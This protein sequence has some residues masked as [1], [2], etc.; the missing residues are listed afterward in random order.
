MVVFFFQAED[1]IRDLTVTG[2]QTC[3]L[4]ISPAALAVAR[5]ASRSRGPRQ[6]GR[7][8]EAAG[9]GGAWRGRAHDGACKKVG[10]GWWKLVEVGGG[11]DVCGA[12]ST[13]LHHPAPTSYCPTTTPSNVTDRGTTNPSVSPVMSRSLQRLRTLTRIFVM[14]VPVPTCP[15]STSSRFG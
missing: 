4:P 5:V 13:I 15:A 3:A 6:G 10:G 7:G 9:A 11:L 12:T 2:V 1:G 8:G 14:R